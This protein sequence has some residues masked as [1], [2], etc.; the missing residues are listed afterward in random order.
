MKRVEINRV[1]P[2]TGD[3]L[4]SDRKAGIAIEFIVLVKENLLIILKAEKHIIMTDSHFISTFPIKI[5]KKF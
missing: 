3:I 4:S 2:V 1:H 5:I